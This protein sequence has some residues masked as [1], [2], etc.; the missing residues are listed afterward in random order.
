MG[1]FGKDFLL[2]FVP[3]FVAVDAIGIL[4]MFI[5][6]TEGM[7]PR[8]RRKTVRDSVITALCVAVGF[9]FL[10]KSIFRLLDISPSDFLVAGGVLL[11][12][13]ATMDLI[14]GRKLAREAGSVGVVPLGTPLIVGPAVLTTSLMLVDLYSL[15]PTLLAVV[16]NVA[17]A[18][19]VFLCADFLTRLLGQT[20]TRAISKIVSLIL[21]AIAVMMVRKGVLG[22][23]SAASR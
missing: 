10:G 21:A 8:W 4:P 12:L 19:G 5:N 1:T 9:V 6:L 14:S 16:V 20:G 13:I 7:D 2:A 11:F 22:I 18:G 17:V 3:I 15:A 23:I